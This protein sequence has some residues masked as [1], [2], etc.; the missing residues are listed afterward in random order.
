LGYQGSEGDVHV[1]GTDGSGDR[2]GDGYLGWWVDLDNPHLSTSDFG[3]RERV[4]VSR[5][6]HV[7]SDNANLHRPAS[8]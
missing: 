7:A 8:V 3:L 1:A 5:L 2:E 4:Q 6:N